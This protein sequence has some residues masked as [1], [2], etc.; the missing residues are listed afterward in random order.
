MSNHV[1]LNFNTVP[2]LA[3]VYIDDG[4]DHFGDNN[5]VSEVGSDGLGLLTVRGVFLGLSELLDESIVSLV[6]S[7][8]KS[9]SLSG[10]E[11][12]DEL[13]HIEF[14][15]SVQLNTSISTLLEGLLLFSGCV[16]GNLFWA[17][18]CHCL[19]DALY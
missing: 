14:K 16:C 7:V 11:E 3:S 12:L 9:S 19:Y 18:A 15:E 6:D 13:V 8:S 17:L 1:S 10:S 5:A 4:S 2:I